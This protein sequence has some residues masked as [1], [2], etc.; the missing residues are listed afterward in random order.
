MMKNSFDDDYKLFWHKSDIEQRFGFRGARFTNV[1]PRFS[2]LVAFVTTSCFFTALFL[3]PKLP[4]IK[5]VSHAIKYV[6]ELCTNRGFTQYPTV[7]FGVWTLVIL[8]VKWLKLREQKKALKLSVLP[9]IHDFIISRN[10]ADSVLQVIH[11][12]APE[13]HA[14]LL[15]HRMISTLS[16]LKNLGRISDVDDILRSHAERDE[17]SLETS[18]T[19]IN[20]FLWAIPV[21]GF[22]GTVIGL[23]QAIGSFGSVLTST[24]ELEAIAE[25][26]RHVT[27]GLMTAFD[28]TLLA[29]VVALFLY[30][31]AT[32]LRKNE[33]EF[34]DDCA[35]YCNRHIVQHLRMSLFEGEKE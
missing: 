22:V 31:S 23:S 29:L 19:L 9:G 8:G 35:E 14:Y 24:S 5:F 33:E 12:I 34:L 11:S 10:T 30:L 1:N 3:L 13:P 16:N 32:A 28:T 4:D 21:F 17:N 18:Y 27:A 6:S 26:L 2:F 7:F 15:Y 25:S 20:G